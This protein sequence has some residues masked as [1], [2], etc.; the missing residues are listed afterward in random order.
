M[1]SELDSHNIGLSLTLHAGVSRCTSL[2][3]ICI[4]LLLLAYIILEYI[5][6]VLVFC[7]M[8]LDD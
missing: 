3:G 4:L 1:W 6:F 7:D 8:A 5:L 2:Y